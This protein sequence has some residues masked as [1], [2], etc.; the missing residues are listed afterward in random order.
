M[1]K[2]SLVIERRNQRLVDVLPPEFLSGEYE[3]TPAMKYA[4]TEVIASYHSQDVPWPGEHRYVAIWHVLANNKAVGWNENPRRG[5]SF[6]VI[7]H[8]E[9]PPD[10]ALMHFANTLHRNCFKVLMSYGF[11]P[12]VTD[13]LVVGHLFS[14]PEKP[15][16][17]VLKIVDGDMEYYCLKPNGETYDEMAYT[18]DEMEWITST[19]D[20][21]ESLSRE[22]N[23]LIRVR[24]D[25]MILND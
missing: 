13:D 6:P 4:F 17:V 5:W 7:K 22:L 15:V 19:A 14:H 21:S 10:Y 9:A 8:R 3:N 20:A 23:I 16:K 24:P 25:V 11:D 1:N 2:H 12:V 18:S